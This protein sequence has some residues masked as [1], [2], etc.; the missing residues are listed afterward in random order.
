MPP[1]DVTASTL[2]EIRGRHDAFVRSGGARLTR[3]E[4]GNAAIRSVV[5]VP[6]LLAAI[7]AALKLHVPVDRGRVMRCCEGCEEVNGEFHEDCCHEW[8]CPTVEDITTALTGE[9]PDG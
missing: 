3:S 9:T 6:F 5:D 4:A 1:D 7:E 8:P 2:A